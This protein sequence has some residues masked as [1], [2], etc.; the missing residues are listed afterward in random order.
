MMD[1]FD[2]DGHLLRKDLKITFDTPGPRE[3]RIVDL[4][5]LLLLTS[6]ERPSTAGCQ[7]NARPYLITSVSFTGNH[8]RHG[9]IALTENGVFR[10]HSRKCM[11][12]ASEKLSALSCCLPQLCCAEWAEPNLAKSLGIQGECSI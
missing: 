3:Q 2:S 10:V 6:E 4:C 1:P 11:R 5:V 12:Y 8:E 7:D 9:S